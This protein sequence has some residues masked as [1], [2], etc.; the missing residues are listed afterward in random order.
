MG[1]LTQ[2]QKEA[3]AWVDVAAGLASAETGPVSFLIAAAASMAYYKD[4][5]ANEGWMAVITEE[6]TLPSTS[7]NQG[8]LHNLLCEKYLTDG[9]DEVKYSE[10]IITAIKVRPDLAN[11]INAIPEDYFHQ[12][13]EIAQQVNL[14][15]P[16]DKMN[17]IGNTVPVHGADRN[18]LFQSL[19]EIENSSSDDEFQDKVQNAI[20]AIP[21]FEL[22]DSDKIILTNSFEILRNSY[23]LWSK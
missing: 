9:Y 21:N 23:Q 17:M 1:Q 8:V 18:L 20:Q 4:K 5:V 12:K 22:N 2:Q 16:D 10:T 3:I 6:P 15:S 7:N 14:S 13:V 19:V 11:A